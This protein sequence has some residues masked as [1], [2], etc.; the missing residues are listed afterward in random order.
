LST[1]AVSKMSL[2]ILRFS[3]FLY[4]SGDTTGDSRVVIKFH[5]HSSYPE[6]R[7]PPT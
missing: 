4:T 3:V 6:G 5:L 1:D 7:T 2:K